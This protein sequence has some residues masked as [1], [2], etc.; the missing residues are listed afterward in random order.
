VDEGSKALRR[1]AM[2]W[3]VIFCFSKQ[4]NFT[5]LIALKERKGRNV[6]NSL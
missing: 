6:E 4:K 1:T 5:E 3:I 2:V